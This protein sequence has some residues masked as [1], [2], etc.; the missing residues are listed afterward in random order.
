MKSYIFVLFFLLTLSITAQTCFPNCKT[1]DPGPN[2]TV[3]CSACNDR[4]ALSSTACSPCSPNCN[5]C[6][7]SGCTSCDGGTYLSS[8]SC[9]GC[10]G[11]FCSLCPGNVCT[12]CSSNYGFIIP[13]IQCSL[14]TVSSCIECFSNHLICNACSLGNG[15]TP[16]NTCEPCNLSHC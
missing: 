13:T 10:S 14:C 5:A 11:S 3:S 6:T 2:S 12:A 4:F 8:S 15:V 16:I 9:I 1:C 7:T